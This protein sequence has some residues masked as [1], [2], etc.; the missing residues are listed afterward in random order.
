MINKALTAI[1]KLKGI[2]ERCYLEDEKKAKVHFDSVDS[3]SWSSST[4]VT[5][6]SVEK[7]Q[8]ISDHIKVNADSITLSTTI[9]NHTGISALDTESLNRLDGLDVIDSVSERL[10][11]L[12]EWQKSGALLTYYGAVWEGVSNCVITSLGPSRNSGSGE[13][14]ELSVSMQ[15]VIIA[16][17]REVAM[18]IPPSTRETNRKGLA[19]T[20][21]K[22]VDMSNTSQAI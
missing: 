4:S 8:N 15:K 16:E 18:D 13:A 5:N 22:T 20:D 7:G 6:Y 9:T 2:P 10:G 1:K 17:H 3:E 19:K 21:T 12:V 11:K 14:V